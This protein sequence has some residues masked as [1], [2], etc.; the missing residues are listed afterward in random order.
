MEMVALTALG[1]GSALG[2]RFK[3][4]VLLPAIFIGV[5]VIT[6]WQLARGGTVGSMALMN[7]ACVTCLQ[8]GYLGGAVMGSLSRAG[9][10]GG[11]KGSKS[12]RPIPH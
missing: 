6:A 11:A 7:V 3:V 4:L 2:L 10:L 12:V 9:R 8:F 5:T 1:I